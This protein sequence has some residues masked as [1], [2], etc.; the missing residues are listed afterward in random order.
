MFRTL[1]YVRKCC[2]YIETT[3]EKTDN[4]DPTIFLEENSLAKRSRSRSP[5]AT[6]PPVKRNLPVHSRT[7][8]S[9]SMAE[10]FLQHNKK[11]L[12]SYTSSPLSRKLT[13]SKTSNYTVC[14]FIYK[15]KK[16]VEFKE[17]IILLN[18]KK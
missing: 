18:C 3:D 17:R 4:I 16:G 1:N 8:T 7:Q 6:P 13:D 15:R 11:H 5:S 2:K 9:A 14:I 12:T 10:T